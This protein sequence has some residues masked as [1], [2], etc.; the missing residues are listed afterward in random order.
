MTTMAPEVSEDLADIAQRLLKRVAVL[1]QRITSPNFV[2][3]NGSSPTF[4][5]VTLGTYKDGVS[6][7]T[8]LDRTSSSPTSLSLTPGST[9]EDITVTGSW[10]A[11]VDGSAAE[12]EFQLFKKDP[13]TLAYTLARITRTFG[14]SATIGG[15]QPN[16]TYGARVVAINR[17]GSSSTP[18]PATGYT[19]VNTTQDATIPAAPTGLAATAGATSITVQWNDNA[20]IDVAK[21]SGMYRIQRALDAGFTSGVDTRLSASTIVSYTGLTPGT[22]Y[23]FRVLAIDSSNNEGP[24][25]S[26]VSAIPGSTGGALSDGSPPAS[27]PAATV[28]SGI[29]YLAVR[30][31]AITNA[32]YVTYEVHL[33][34]SNGFTPNAGTKVQEVDGTSVVLTNDV[35]GATLVYGTTYY[36]KIIAKDRDGAA[37]AGTQG[38]GTP[39]RVGD[40][41]VTTLSGAKVKDGS[42]P[43]SSPAAVAQAGFGSVIVRWSPIT[44]NDPVIYEVHL[45]TSSGFTPN[46]GT[47]VAQVDGTYVALRTDAAGA[48]LSYASTYYAKVIA[49]DA[50]G[51]AAAGAQSA[52]VTPM[53]VDSVDLSTA[54]NGTINTAVTDIAR[55]QSQLGGVNLIKQPVVLADMTPANYLSGATPTVAID[56]THTRGDQVSFMLTGAPA[57]GGT[58]FTGGNLSYSATNIQPGD[59]ILSAYVWVETLPSL[60]GMLIMATATKVTDSTEALDPDGATFAWVR[61][62]PAYAPKITTTGQWV[63]GTCK[64]RVTHEAN[65]NMYAI[66]DGAATEN[67]NWKF[68]VT[69]WQLEA[70]T[71]A[72]EF[73]LGPEDLK[74]RADAAQTTANGKNRIYYQNSA[75][76]GILVEGDLWFDTDD[77]NKPYK[78]VAGAWQ[79]YQL[80]NSAILGNL[81]AG[82]ITTGYLA[83]GIIQAN[84]ITAD[85]LTITTTGDNIVPN[86]SFEDAGD[87]VSNPGTGLAIARW[88]R[89]LVGTGNAFQEEG[90]AR[91]V[92]GTKVVTLYASGVGSDAHVISDKIPVVGGSTY[93]VRVRASASATPSASF[94]FRVAWYSESAL[95]SNSDVVTNYQLTTGLPPDTIEAQIVA[96]IGARYC[97]VQLRN[98]APASTTYIWVDDVQM[99]RVV[100]SAGIA[101]GAITAPKIVAGSVTTEKLT[102]VSFGDNLIP[103]GGFDELQAA[104]ATQPAK[105]SDNAGG[106]SVNP[107]PFGAPR[108]PYSYDAAAPAGGIERSTFSYGIP[109]SAN[110]TYYWSVDY[111][112]NV[113]GDADAPTATKKQD[114][115]WMVWFDRE[116]AAPRGNGTGLIWD[117]GNGY[118]GITNLAPFATKPTIGDSGWHTLSGQV[119]P[120]TNAKYGCLLLGTIPQTTGGTCYQT[121]DNAVLRPVQVAASIGNNEITAANIKTGTLTSASGIFGTLDASVITAGAFTAARIGAQTIDTGKISALGLDAAVI[122]FGTMHGDRIQTNSLTANRL[123]VQMGG[124]NLISNSGFDNTAS[125]LTGWTTAGTPSRETTIV[126]PGSVASVKFTKTGGALQLIQHNTQQVLLG[127]G[128]KVTISAW[129]YVVDAALAPKINLSGVVDMGTVTANPAIVN[130]WQRVIGTYTI[131]TAGVYHMRAYTDNGANGVF[132]VDDMQFEYGDVSTM[133]TPKVDEILPGT[134]S[135]AMIVAGSIRSDNGTIGQL[136]ASHINTGTMDAGYITT[137]TMNVDRLLSTN[138]LTS[139][140]L[141]MGTGSQIKIGNPGVAGQFGILIDPTGIRAYQGATETIRLDA[142]NGI[143]TFTGVL[144]AIGGTFAGNITSSATISGGTIIGSTFKSGSTGSRIEIRP[145]TDGVFEGRA[146]LFYPPVGV[147]ATAGLTRINALYSGLDLDGNDLQFLELAAGRR[148][149]IAGWLDDSRI[150]MG[151]RAGVNIY[152]ARAAG[153][154]YAAPVNIYAQ[155]VIIDPSAAD[156]TWG[157][158]DHGYHAV[159]FYDVISFFSNYAGQKGHL[160][161]VNYGGGN[162][163][164]AEWERRRVGI[165]KTTGGGSFGAVTL[166]Y[167]GVFSGRPVTVASHENGGTNNT[168]DA[169]WVYSNSATSCVVRTQDIDN[170]LRNVNVDVSL[171][172]T[173]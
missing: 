90:P 132:Y 143:G 85:K 20:E 56:A 109:V 137:N 67:P 43:A 111:I 99:R 161:G 30:W 145:N 15:L 123:N 152:G 101:D 7:G 29:G 1:E 169:C 33:S 31:T 42:A 93:H 91:A 10:V 131:A 48:A 63:R 37:A 87:S 28:T 164:L 46:S 122:S 23:Y 125:Y 108:S 2:V 36:V 156:S 92:S 57:A 124:G 151:A 158:Y 58:G 119:T 66:T 59:Y 76:T 126:R 41:D 167:Q 154:G 27:S 144:N 173:L 22:T 150:V 84:T 80:G 26:A 133:Y 8:L 112:T 73:R 79:A 83:A 25:S 162:N 159:N 165:S 118:I 129:M 51:A 95:L 81:D 107:S 62:E 86:S 135:A 6:V 172:I 14:L 94:R 142:T 9:F 54:L 65:V 19:D 160:R 134:V 21:G 64:F 140:T 117:S 17:I 100:V 163:S 153:G 11:P 88:Y 170:A 168:N 114:L 147:M 97:Y 130:A 34:T 39:R 138:T 166:T 155:K 96:P 18:L 110:K 115:I 77:D 128:D 74:T 5:D 53:Q 157:S 136:S 116:P 121:W 72:S 139:K 13:I 61:D 40:A 141:I 4:S 127:V 78:Y 69:Q 149:D 104:N 45:S 89:V 32:D 70:G 75:P 3:P 102:V 12:Y 35:A 105:W 55:A 103:N 47:L 68:W 52:G 146:I 16:S 148:Q 49:R 82:K 50:D 171:I 113:N 60:E 38:S 24:Y 120:P 106:M 71:V 98:N 44:N